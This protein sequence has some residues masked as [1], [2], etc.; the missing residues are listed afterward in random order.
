MGPTPPP[1]AAGGASKAVQGT[2]PSTEP[3][4]RV[5]GRLSLSNTLSGDEGL[6]AQ[7][8]PAAAAAL[9]QAQ[10][11]AGGGG[12]GAR[13]PPLRHVVL[14]R[15]IQLDVPEDQVRADKGSPRG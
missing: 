9:Q 14:H 7:G 4:E 11:A 3:P 15:E 2:A 5:Q 1:Q 6:L 12:G 8:A 10:W 13:G